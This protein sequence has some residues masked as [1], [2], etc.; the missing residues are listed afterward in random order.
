MLKNSKKIMD[1]EQRMK[2]VELKAGVIQAKYVTLSHDGDAI[3]VDV[4]AKRL[5]NIVQSESSR[6]TPLQ[7][8]LCKETKELNYEKKG[9]FGWALQQ[10]KEGECVTRKKIYEGDQLAWF[11]LIPKSEERPQAYFMA[12]NNGKEFEWLFESEDLLAEDWVFFHKYDIRNQYGRTVKACIYSLDDG[13]RTLNF[14]EAFKL[15]QEEGLPVKR[16]SWGGYWKWVED[17]IM[18]FTQDNRMIDIR[19]TEK[20]LDTIESLLAED[21]EIAT[22]ENCT[23]PVV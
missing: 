14:V 18:M 3:D 21:W 10:M 2:A 19:N 6:L 20:V 8:G 11:R 1:L 17:T 16:F 13:H 7:T 23:I 12:K 15:M 9:T 4:L 22:K 5:K